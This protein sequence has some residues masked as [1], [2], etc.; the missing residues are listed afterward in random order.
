MLTAR[1]IIIEAWGRERIIIITSLIKLHSLLA[2]LDI[3]PVMNH[4]LNNLKGLGFV[5]IVK[6]IIEYQSQ[7]HGETQFL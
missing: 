5:L 2:T 6:L 7:N 1:P 4:K 3:I